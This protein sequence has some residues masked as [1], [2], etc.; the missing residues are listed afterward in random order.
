MTPARASVRLFGAPTISRSGVPSAVDTRKAIALL[1]YL[2]LAG[3]PVQRDRLCALLWPESSQSRAR[4]A[5]R[6]TLTS[7]RSAVGA[8]VVIADRESVAVALDKMAVDVA[9]FERLAEDGSPGDLA[10]A[11]DLYEGDFLSGFSVR[12]SPD[13]EDWQ[14]LEAERFRR[15]ADL[16]LEQLVEAQLESGDHGSAIELAERRVNLDPLSEPAHRQLL[17]AEARAGHR[18]RAIERYRT[19]A[20]ILE[21]ELGVA[22][23]PET[24]ELYQRIRRGEIPADRRPDAAEAPSQV[25]PAPVIASFVGRRRELADLLD[26]HRR[27]S[28]GGRLV[29]V[30]GE[31]GIGK[32]ALVLE[33]M[34]L[35]AQQGSRVAQ[36]RCHEGER[37]LP[38]APVA[39]LLRDLYAGFG[40]ASDLEPSALRAIAAL[41]PEA[42]PP[43]PDAD[44][45]PGVDGRIRFYEALRSGVEALCAGGSPSFLVVDDLHLADHATAEFFAY[46]TRRM[47]D[48]AMCLVV[49]WRG[50]EIPGEGPLPGMVAAAQRSGMLD[51]VELGPLE[52]TSLERL[53]HDASGGSVEAEAVNA[54][55]DQSAGVPFFAIEY[56][57][58]AAAG[59]SALPMPERVRGLLAARLDRAGEVAAQLLA[60]AAVLG[61][62]FDV[63]LVRSVSGR[64]DEEVADALDDLEALAIFER[65]SEGIAPQYDFTHERLREVAYQKVAAG[66]R[67]LLHRRAAEALDALA[68]P[69]AAEIREAARH[70]EASGDPAHAA[71]L[72]AKAGHAARSVHANA[73]AEECFSAA[74]TL[75]HPDVAG[76]REARGDVATLRGTY[77]VGIG[78]YEGAAALV[79]GAALARI[80]HKLGSVYS[81]LGDRRAA[82]SYFDAALR[83]AA[84]EDRVQ[85][86]S[87]FAVNWYRTG[88][89]ATAQDLARQALDLAEA[90]GSS[91]EIARAANVAGLLARSTGDFDLAV[92]DLQRSR[93]AA[94][95]SGDDDMYIA[96]LNNL[97]LAHGGLGDHGT[98]ITILDEALVKCRAIGD[99]HREAALLSNLGDARFAAGLADDAADAVKRSATILSEI[100]RQ[101]E[102]FIPEVW[103][104]TEW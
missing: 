99:R 22:P 35:A 50:D 62:A 56:A 58:A 41:V 43:G 47:S 31:P 74:L 46:L 72:Y 5:L 38:Y 68:R 32:T 87:D 42:T 73:E 103:K 64:T 17:V 16:V 75:G 25:N 36:A 37:D 15:K 83:G 4:G 9:E 85:V 21:E 94:S 20:R 84:D 78:E 104:L 48:I 3:G 28:G 40:G 101:G 8:D 81:R 95:S 33:A 23:L 79:E 10:R 82:Q 66:R 2:T 54:I 96:A 80:E 97:A 55:L 12:G 59:G 61:R 65:S 98:A 51:T 14:R 89:I 93:D 26:A 63:S 88:E 102:A 52:G 44:S 34:R 71:D 18:S 100:G 1:A 24:T 70:A 53:I 7:L 90:S 11:V 27:S 19:A 30:D 60:A 67:R 45:L 76:L 77:R 49:A 92:S 57:R 86:L 13:F 39:Q 29:A 91:H 69:A 6:R